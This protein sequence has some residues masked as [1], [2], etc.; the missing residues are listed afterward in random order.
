[1]VFRN[2]KSGATLFLLMI[3]PGT[4]VAAMCP[5]SVAQIRFLHTSLEQTVQ[6]ERAWSTRWSIGWASLTTVQLA[7][8]PL[9]SSDDKRK[10]LTI[11]AFGSAMGLVPTFIIQPRALWSHP[12]VTDS[13]DSCDT[14]AMLVTRLESAAADE[15]FMHS[16]VSHAAGMVFSVGLGMVLG[17][18]YH[19]WGPAVASMAFGLTASELM[20][21]DRPEVAV[22]A[23]ARYHAGNY[24]DNGAAR[25]GQALKLALLLSQ[26]VAGIGLSMGFK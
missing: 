23:L 15:R 9:I 14:L 19:H 4:G 25:D 13:D 21:G 24:S 17:F 3:L 7:A 12:P 16:W 20:I 6:R 5:D 1:M 8:A 22:D 26:D 11:G 18:G 10:D 2:L